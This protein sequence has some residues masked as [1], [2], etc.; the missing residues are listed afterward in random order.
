MLVCPLH[1]QSPFLAW[2][3]FERSDRARGRRDDHQR[4]AVQPRPIAG[5]FLGPAAVSAGVSVLRA[6]CAP[7]HPAWLEIGWALGNEE[8]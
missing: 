2:T 8:L 1:P 4:P 3:D 7:A 5:D 6:A